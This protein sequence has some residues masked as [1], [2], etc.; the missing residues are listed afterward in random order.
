MLKKVL[1]SLSLMGTAQAADMV[2]IAPAHSNDS[3]YEITLEHAESQSAMRLV[4]EK[5]GKELAEATKEFFFTF[6]DGSLKYQKAGNGKI[7]V[8]ITIEKSAD[9]SLS[10]NLG[11]LV[12]SGGASV[13]GS[14]YK[15]ITIKVSG[16]KEEVRKIIREVLD[17]Q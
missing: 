2:T 10:G 6:P 8:E 11:N 9:G 14:G 12:T 1:L 4:R 17:T 3:T 7:S 16:D 15:K 13:S 5:F